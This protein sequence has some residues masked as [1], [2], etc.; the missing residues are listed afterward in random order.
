[1]TNPLSVR[2]RVFAAL[3]ALTI[4]TLAA[5]A[6][7]DGTTFSNAVLTTYSIVAIAGCAYVVY[8]FTRMAVTGKL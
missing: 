8:D 3:V 6:Y 5:A 1:M 2:Q 4:P 7:Y